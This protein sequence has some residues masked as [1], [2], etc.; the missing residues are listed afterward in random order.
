MIEAVEIQFCSWDDLPIDQSPIYQTLVA[1]I[2][3]KKCRRMTYWHPT[4][5]PKLP[6][7]TE[8]E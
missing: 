4:P 7:L 5:L 3:E 1:E 8:G 2:G 6:L